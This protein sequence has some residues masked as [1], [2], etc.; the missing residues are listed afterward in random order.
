MKKLYI[1]SAFLLT[2]LFYFSFNN[3]SSIS[4]TESSTGLQTVLWDGGKTEIEFADI[5]RDGY[6][7]ILSIGD[8]GNPNINTQEHGVM[9]YFGNGSGSNWN[10]FQFGNFGYGGIAIGDINND[11]IPDIA[12]GM[13][14]NYSSNDL[15]NQ[16]LEAALGDGTG[17]NWTAWD[18][19]LAT[20]GETYGMFTTDFGD[21]DNDGKLDIG[22]ISFGCCA[23]VHIY[24]NLGTGVWRQSF[25]FTGGNTS[26]EFQFGDINNDGYLDFA[27]AHQYG[28]PYF[29]DG[30]G[31]FTLR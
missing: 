21:V 8:H 3:N 22:S 14:H 25:G 16:I 10:L 29:G 15:G 17:M 31:N 4:Y 13:H 20:N 1:I 27:V 6:K 24:R 26:M 9:V 28:T 18:D 11:N 5:N 2:A 19:S 30:N 23:G 12:Y 7:D